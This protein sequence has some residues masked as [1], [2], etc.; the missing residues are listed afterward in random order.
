MNEDKIQGAVNQLAFTLRSLIRER[1]EAIRERDD[2]RRE[3]DVR[4]KDQRDL[5]I[6]LDEAIK[7]RDRYRRLWMEI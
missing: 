5:T 6:L 7:E 2:L 1:D 3:R 4:K